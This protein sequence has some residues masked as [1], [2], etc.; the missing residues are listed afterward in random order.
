MDAFGR[1]VGAKRTRN[2]AA[3]EAKLGSPGRLRWLFAPVEQRV[4]VAIQSDIIVPT[5]QLGSVQQRAAHSKVKYRVVSN[6]R[7]VWIC[8]AVRHAAHRP[9]ERRTAESHS[10][11]RIL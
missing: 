2:D 3:G 10:K 9:R 6:R 1:G 11:C 4:R 5:E 8:P 7:A